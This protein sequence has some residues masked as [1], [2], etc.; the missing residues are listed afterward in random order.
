MIGRP[1]RIR[2][3][4]LCFFREGKSQ[5][6]G[7]EGD[8]RRLLGHEQFHNADL[9][10]AGV[11]VLLPLPVHGSALCVE[12]HNTDSEP[13]PHSSCTGEFTLQP[14]VRTTAWKSGSK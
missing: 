12:C 4:L 7:S 2:L 14:S 3:T 6:G 5:A 10:E 1:V 13:G 9:S 8:G 11:G